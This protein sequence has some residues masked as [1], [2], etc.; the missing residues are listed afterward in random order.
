[1]II[2]SENSF[3][4]LFEIAKINLLLFFFYEKH[5][6]AFA[7]SVKKSIFINSIFYVWIVSQNFSPVN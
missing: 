6:V 4:S 7:L 1:M 5:V 3:R 2:L